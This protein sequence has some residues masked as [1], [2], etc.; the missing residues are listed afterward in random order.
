MTKMFS[1]E[2]S[3]V[4]C[5]PQD[6]MRVFLNLISNGMYAANEREAS[7][8]QK[9]VRIEPAI[10]VMTRDLGDK[11]AIEIRDN[12]AGIPADIQEKIFTPFFT[13][14]PAGE[15]TG[16][17]LSLSYDIVVKQH[18]GTMSVESEPDEFT[19]FVVTVPHVLP[20]TKTDG[21]SKA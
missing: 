12:G 8:G 3:E 17:G 14:K 10:T 15:G 4:E 18:G 2:V 1:P 19:V 20:E 21:A 11:V 5:Y 9:A 7:A 13:T 6:L 16:L